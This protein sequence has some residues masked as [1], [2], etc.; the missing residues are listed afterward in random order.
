MAYP[1]GPAWT[2]KAL[3]QALLDSPYGITC[4]KSRN[5]IGSQNWI[6]QRSLNQVTLI[7]ALVVESEDEGILP[8]KLRNIVQSLGLDAKD[9]GLELG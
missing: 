6:L 2:Y 4:Q 9:Y 8:S 3:L 1:F 7:C 5:R